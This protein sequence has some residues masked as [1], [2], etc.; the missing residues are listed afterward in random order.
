[1][2]AYA[3]L[4]YMSAEEVMVKGRKRR[5]KEEKKKTDNSLDIFNFCPVEKKWQS[6]P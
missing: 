6:H 1:M 3:F 2:I 5:E 4:G